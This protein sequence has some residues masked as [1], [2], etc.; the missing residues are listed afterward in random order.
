ML[1]RDAMSSRVITIAA[2]ASIA[3]AMRTMLEHRISGM[4]VLD[5]EGHLA[6]MIT[7][8]DFLRRAEIDTQQH[9]SRW[10]QLLL[11]PGKL[12]AEY[13]QSRG[14]TVEEIMAH[15]LV[16]IGAD[17]PLAQAVE[18]MQQKHIKR[19]PVIEHGRLTGMLSRADLMRACLASV[20]EDTVAPLGDAATAARITQEMDRQPWCPR[21]NIRIEVRNGDADLIGVVTDERTRNALR[22]LVENTLGVR[23][24]TDHLI[25]VEPKTGTIVHTASDV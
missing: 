24:V 8:G 9:H 18:L 19:L 11:S 6:G 17:A 12:A 2:Q 22:I 15:E 10:L 20:P 13:T 5:M 4:P 7:E 21:A 16:T 23:H 1:V 14:G 3:E 25:T